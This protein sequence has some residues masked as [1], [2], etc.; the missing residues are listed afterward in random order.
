[1]PSWCPRAGVQPDSPQRTELAGDRAPPG[2][3]ELRFEGP[4]ACHV[5]TLWCPHRDLLAG[6]GVCFVGSDIKGNTIVPESELSNWYEDH[7]SYFFEKYSKELLV[8]VKTR[9]WEANPDQ[10]IPDPG[11]EW[12]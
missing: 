4:A 5:S 8:E 11:P 1:M 7:S 3:R 2:S 6:R 9:L 12:G 10:G